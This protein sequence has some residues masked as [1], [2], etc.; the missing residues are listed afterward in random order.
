LFSNTVDIGSGFVPVTAFSKVAYQLIVEY[1][2]RI[3]NSIIF[4]VVAPEL[5]I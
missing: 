3:G 2:I 5:N 1:E 4:A